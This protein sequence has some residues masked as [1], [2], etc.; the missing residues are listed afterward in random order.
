LALL[1]FPVKF[2][3]G[4]DVVFQSPT[5]RINGSMIGEKCSHVALKL[6]HQDV[7]CVEGTFLRI[8]I[9]QPL[10]RLSGRRGVTSLQLVQ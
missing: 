7:E 3:T 10:P 6:A 2:D 9:S 4:L 8:F 1:H 5:R